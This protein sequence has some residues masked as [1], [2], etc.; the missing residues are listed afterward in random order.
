MVSK[1]NV[2]YFLVFYILKFVSAR[3]FTVVLDTTGS[4]K[5]EIE[6]VQ[7]YIPDVVDILKNTTEFNNYVLV[8]F[9]DAEYVPPPLIT[10]NPNQ[11]MDN[12]NNLRVIGGSECPEDSLS[13]IEKALE[14]SEPESKIYLFTDGNA[15][16]IDKLGDIKKLCRDTGSQVVIFLSGTCSDRDPGGVGYVDV[17]YDIARSCS[18]TVFNIAAV[19][20][21]KA[22]KYIKDMVKT[23]Y[24]DIVNH[25]AF[26]GYQQFSF[27]IDAVTTDV[28]I[29]LSGDYPVLSISDEEGYSP[30]MDKMV[31][32]RQSLV[33]R[34]S[35]L[36]AGTYKANAR[37]QG[38]TYVTFYKRNRLIFEYG[39]CTRL[40][41]SLK[42]TSLRPIPGWNNYI[43]V[44][45]PETEGLKVHQLE[46]EFIGSDRKKR[47][48]L[49]AH[50]SLK[51][52]YI[53]SLLIEPGK[54]FKMTII[55][56]DI[57]TYNDIKGTTS[58]IEIQSPNQEAKWSSPT[59]EIIQ[60]ATNLINYGAN[61]TVACKVVGFPKPTIEW[62]DDDGNSLTSE[63][64]LLEIPSI[65]LSYAKIE[66]MSSNFTLYC[67][68]KNA[69]GSDMSSLPMF[70]KRTYHFDVIQSPTDQA[71][72]YATEG[73]LYCEVDAYPEAEI[74]WR[75]N[76]ITLEDS[77]NVELNSEDKALI[78]KNMTLGDEG[79]YTCEV[80]NEANR[81]ELSAIVTISGIE[82]PQV[83]L[84]D[85]LIRTPEDLV[86]VNCSIEQGYPV[87]NV[88]WEFR[89]N[90]YEEF[91]EIP[92]DADVENNILRISSAKI[93]H[94]G[95]YKCIAVNMLGE[96]SSTVSLKIQ[97]APKITDSD[98]SSVEVTQGDEVELPCEVDAIPDA[99]VRWELYQDDVIINLDDRHTTDD[100]HTHKF[101]AQWKDSGNYHCIAQNDMGSV[102]K[103]IKVN[104][105]V[106]P[107]IQEES[108]DVTLRTG[109]S[110]AFNCYV[111]I[112]GNPAPTTVW[113][114]INVDSVKT[115][116]KRGN[117][118]TTLYL[119]NV[120]KANEGLY[121]CIVR[122][123]VSFDRIRINVTVH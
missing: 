33:V 24:N 41:N 19:N 99:S 18:G 92:Y 49:E 31:D 123:K 14:I 37:A 119:N 121:L 34:L 117:S 58:I 5:F 120:S 100:K 42:E 63:D 2:V 113:E 106:P 70:V 9:N 89:S 83:K 98:D 76:G 13:A 88:T 8:T 73:K 7:T 104:V 52:F 54:P 11:L 60:P 6:E 84:P 107:F 61:A 62:E 20:I 36:K 110:V 72:E 16:Y 90:D 114:F 103:H 27:V 50:P 64:V 101:T 118:N 59:S 108:K 69:N 115:V 109:S 75:R 80:S 43:L 122:N 1:S 91:G 3:S 4:M 26:T 71:V 48:I 29:A 74:I 81:K 38:Q 32:T 116:L 82:P 57:T 87:P 47:I 111:D 86:E 77:N 102:E 15:K 96:H 30:V 97:Y 25:D 10:Q 68:C 78:I 95:E 65:H 79:K 112:Y 85:E 66:N 22:F 21:R 39:F 56:K 105:L 46:M 94:N 28:L 40:P 51:G 12:L 93:E 44:A 53:A 45:M 35:N 17:Y 55:A 23:D 67:K